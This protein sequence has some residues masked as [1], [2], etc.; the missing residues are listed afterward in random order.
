MGEGGTNERN[1][2]RTQY[3]QERKKKELKNQKLNKRKLL[4]LSSM[5][6]KPSDTIWERRQERG[7]TRQGFAIDRRTHTRR[8]HAQISIFFLFLGGIF[9]LKKQQTIQQIVSLFLPSMKNSLVYKRWEEN[10][11]TRENICLHTREELNKLKTHTHLS[12][13]SHQEKG[14]QQNKQ[15]E[16]KTRT[17][18]L[19]DS[20]FS[21]YANTFI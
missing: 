1:V 20:L 19:S 18:S 21:A 7:K 9:I 14:T 3:W 2:T 16:L 11:Q 6:D 12:L 17:G 8:R 10:K 4:K 13:S 15:K 5:Q